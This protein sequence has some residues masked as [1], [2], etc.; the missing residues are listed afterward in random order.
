MTGIKKFPFQQVEVDEKK[1]L[2]NIGRNIHHIRTVKK[3]SVRLL[4]LQAGVD[5]KQLYRI[6]NAQHHAG[7]ITIFRIAKALN[8]NMNDLVNGTF[9]DE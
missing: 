5:E 7:I 9:D 2:N 6:E 8:V 1:I 4:A 3:E